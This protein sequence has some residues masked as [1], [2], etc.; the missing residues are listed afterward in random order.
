MERSTDVSGFVRN[1]GGISGGASAS[2][3]GV[4][5]ARQDHPPLVTRLVGI[6]T[7]LLIMC[8]DLIGFEQALDGS[9]PEPTNK[10]T[11]SPESYPPCS[12]EDIVSQIEQIT[13][14]IEAAHSRIARRF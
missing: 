11:P 4:G 8:R 7:Q 2:I 3:L 6:R 12:I 1:N 9:P 14:D 10:T 5:Q 13:R